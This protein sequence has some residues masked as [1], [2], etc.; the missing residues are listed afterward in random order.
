M[1]FA[2]LFMAGCMWIVLPMLYLTNRS[3]TVRR[4]GLLLSV[5]VP[6]EAQEDSD[7]L[8]ACTSYRRRLLRDTLLLTLALLPG[9]FL[10]WSSISWLWS[11]LWLLAALAVM[12]VEYARANRQVKTIKSRRGWKQAPTTRVV[13][14]LRPL[15][16]PRPL[17]VGWFIPPMVLSVLPVVSCLVDPWSDGWRLLLAIT[18]GSG[19]L[20]TAMSLLL[21]RAILH[22][23][24]DVLYDDP[25]LTTALT[26]VRRYNWAKLWLTASWLTAAYSL[27]VWCC[28]EGQGYAVC[29]VL[30]CVA[31][32]AAIL[33]TEFAA[34][35]AQRRLTA[36]V[37]QPSVVDED[38]LWIWGQFY[39]NPYSTRA[40]VNER[41][42]VGMSV[43]FAHPAGKAMLVVI[44]LVLLSLLLLCGWT[45][46]EELSPIRTELSESQITVTQAGSRYVIDREKITQVEMLETLPKASRVVGTGMPDL[47]KG[48]YTVDGYGRCTLCLN[49]TDPPFVVLRTENQTYILSGEV[50]G[51]IPEWSPAPKS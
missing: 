17:A 45:V 33:G 24:K 14:E 29:T 20:V 23:R 7:V 42:G 47:C 5:T 12:T 19:L 35:R 11:V 49:P 6:P 13:A 21:Y 10:P 28:Q 36:S 22:Q 16:L 51:E 48:T 31:L 8:A 18:A 46:W 38:D 32:T 2:N 37:K 50:V 41:V 34:R 27:A 4:N 15:N 3:N 39:Y 25:D 30:Y 44:A 9:V 1:L 43:N 26:Q 40:M